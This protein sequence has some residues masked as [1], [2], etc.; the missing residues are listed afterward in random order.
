MQTLNTSLHY[1]PQITSS[2]IPALSLSK[3]IEYSLKHQHAYS[4]DSKQQL[5][6]GLLEH[7]F[8]PGG[9]YDQEDISWFLEQLVVNSDVS[10]SF[11]SRQPAAI[12]S[13]K[14]YLTRILTV[15]SASGSTDSVNPMD[16]FNGKV[17]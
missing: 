3:L 5:L 7:F 10:F 1:F 8:P 9:A 12:R 17:S 15:S 6:E 2:P 14:L 16:L 11:F 13:L 4:D